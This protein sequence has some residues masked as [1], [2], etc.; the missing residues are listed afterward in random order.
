MPPKKT[1]QTEQDGDLFVTLTQ[2]SADEDQESRPMKD[3]LLKLDEVNKNLQAISKNIGKIFK[4]MS[5]QVKEQSNND[6]SDTMTQTLEAVKELVVATRT[7]QPL[8]Q[9][10]N[11]ITLEQEALK[12]KDSIKII[13]NQK[14]TKR[15]QEY[16]QKCRNENL[17]KTYE[18]WRNRTPIILPQKLQLREINGEPDDQHRVRERQ[19]IDNFKT[20]R[21]LLDLRA[22][23][24]EEHF[25]KIDEEMHSIISQKTNGRRRTLLLDMWRNDCKREEDISSKRW[26]GNNLKWNRK[27]ENLF[28]EKYNDS[29]P[30]IFKGQIE[31][32]TEGRNQTQ[33]NDVHAS[34]PRSTQSMQTGQRRTQQPET[35]NSTYANVVRGAATNRNTEF[36]R[37]YN[38]GRNFESRDTPTYIGRNI[39][40]RGRNAPRYERNNNTGDNPQRRTPFN[41]YNNQGNFNNYR[42][43]AQPNHSR[44]TEQYQNTNTRFLENP[45]YQN[46][47]Y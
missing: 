25:K 41:D 2:P 47:P 37:Q 34:N 30:F 14:L 16:W 7:Q 42:H 31:V 32:T 23:T 45:Y 28:T 20:E 11:D 3:V 26:E 38:N 43:E 24:H 15:K 18:T 5:D 8:L 19:V 10:S 27:Y 1:T 13:W 39:H 6:D 36:Q 21:E 46:R 4:F 44:H 22:Q 17:S 35:R 40:K 33:R 12:I 9:E 29:N